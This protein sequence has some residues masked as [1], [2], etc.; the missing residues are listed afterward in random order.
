MNSLQSKGRWNTF[1]GLIFR[2]YPVAVG[3]DN[4]TGVLEG[5]SSLV[6]VGVGVSLGAGVRVAVGVAVLVGTGVGV[7]VDVGVKVGVL[8]GVGGT[9]SSTSSA[10]G[11]KFGEHVN[12]LFGPHPVVFPAS[13]TRSH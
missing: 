3:A 6:A 13:G 4:W 1:G 7:K 10:S 5:V 2:V 9:L 8:V 12:A 11:L